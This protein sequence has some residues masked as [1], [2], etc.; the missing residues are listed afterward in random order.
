MKTTLL[1]ITVTAM[2]AG[3]FAQGKI[4]I[5]NDWNHLVYS[6]WDMSLVTGPNWVV[7]L[8]GY[9]G[10]NAGSLALLTSVPMNPSLPG[11]FG[12][13]NWI[14][15]LPGGSPSTFQVRIR[16]LNVG[17]VEGF[18]QIFTMQPGASLAYNSL[19]NPG[20]TTLST[21]ANGT[22]PVQGGFG[23]IMVPG[24]CPEPSTLAL[25]GLGLASLL[26]FHRRK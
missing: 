8:Y 14:S 9:A 25:S 11:I 6:C 22:V 26:L 1:V 21:W 7:D 13:V 12:P 3:A 19:V 16:D 18:S 5:M 24:L 15:P 20:G 17:W 2:C 23:A 4:S 10:T